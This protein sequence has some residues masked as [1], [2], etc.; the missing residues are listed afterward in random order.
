M[1]S[2]AAWVVAIDSDGRCSGDPPGVQI[3]V[4]FGGAPW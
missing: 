3:R 2:G 4:V 1:F